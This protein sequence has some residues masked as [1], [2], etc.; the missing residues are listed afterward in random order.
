MGIKEILDM[1]KEAGILPFTSRNTPDSKNKQYQLS[2]AKKVY[3]RYVD[4]IL[5]EKPPSW[6]SLYSINFPPDTYAEWLLQN[7]KVSGHPG[8]KKKRPHLIDIIR[9]NQVQQTTPV[10]RKYLLETMGISDY[11]YKLISTTMGYIPPLNQ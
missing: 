6:A 7:I 10:R 4:P 9:G 5:H 3:Q 2:I 1:W 11:S 8:S